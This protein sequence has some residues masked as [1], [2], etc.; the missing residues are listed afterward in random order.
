MTYVYTIDVLTMY[1][2]VYTMY[3]P[4]IYL[5]V[6]HVYTVNITI[7]L[8]VNTRHLTNAGKKHIQFSVQF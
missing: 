5:S 8:L 6:N 3:I 7:I 1:S 4:L 2:Y